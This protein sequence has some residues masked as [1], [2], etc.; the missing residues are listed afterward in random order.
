[1]AS[2]KEDGRVWMRSKEVERITLFEGRDADT[3]D[4]ETVPGTDNALPDEG[5]RRTASS[6][7]DEGEPAR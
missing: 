5:E 7:G 4:D 1:M 3:V 6:M 2:L